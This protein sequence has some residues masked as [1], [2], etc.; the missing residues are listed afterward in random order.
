M[1]QIEGIVR[2]LR[3]MLRAD[4][5]MAELTLRQVATRAAIFALAGLVG[6]FGAVMLGIAGF[7]SLEAVYGPIH[8][9]LIVGGA[10]IA[11]ALL[12]V[13]IALCIR[14]GGDMQAAAAVHAQAVSALGQEL[15]A[16]AASAQRVANLVSNPLGSGVPALLVPIGGLILRW[17]GR[18]KR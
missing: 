14:P 17:L 8:A 3:V 2:N 11:L 7:L 10:A 6:G 4:M 12:L 15:E 18:R 9:A 13:V 16:T 1:T 5:I